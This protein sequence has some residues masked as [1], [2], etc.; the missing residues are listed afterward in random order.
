MFCKNCG[1]VVVGKFCSC[2]GKR[3][4][5]DL[6]EF[7]QVERRAKKEFL[8]NAAIDNLDRMHLADCCWT[9]CEMKYMGKGRICQCNPN[10]AFGG[11][12]YVLAP[13]AYELLQT[14]KQHAQALFDRLIVEDY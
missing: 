9:A 14:V 6:Q 8:R 3:V 2:C 1:A 4:Y 7:R 11:E 10:T 5:S 13:N 12:R